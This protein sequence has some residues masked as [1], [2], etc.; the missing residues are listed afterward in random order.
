MPDFLGLSHT[1][2]LSHNSEGLND[3]AKCYMECGLA[4][5]KRIGEKTMININTNYAGENVS[6]VGSIDR[7]ISNNFSLHFVPIQ[8]DMN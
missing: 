2:H 7:A 1:I 5:S 4:S 3:K 6:V 8:Y